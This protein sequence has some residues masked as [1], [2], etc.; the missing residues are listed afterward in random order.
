[1]IKHLRPTQAPASKPDLYSRL[2]LPGA[3]VTQHRR[4]AS[5]D[6]LRAIAALMVLASHAE[7]LGPTQSTTLSRQVSSLGVGVWIFFAASGYLIAGPFLRAL[8]EGRPLPPVR[9]YALR[10]A[11]RILPAYW[12]ALAAILLLANGSA[13]AHWWQLPVHALLLQGLVPG[14][15]KNLYLVAWSLGV[16]AIFYVL[17]PLGAGAVRRR[18]G[19][20]PISV[21]RMIAGVLVLWIAAVAFSL[22][23]AV[24]FP[25]HG[26][27]PLPGAV[28]VLNLVGS[29]A[30]FCPGMLIFLALTVDRKTDSRLGRRY[31]AIA[32]RPLPT[33]VIAGGLF[34]VA[35]SAL[36]FHT[37][38]VAAAAQGP[39]FGVASGLVLI[40]FLHGEWTRPLAKVFAPIG[41]A[42]Y[43]VY[44]WHFAIYTALLKHGV[45]I[46]PGSGNVAV[47][48]RIAFIAAIT[49]PVAMLS[50]LLVERPLLRRTTG[51]ERRGNASAV[52]KRHRREPADPRVLREVSPAS[53]ATSGP[54]ILRRQSSSVSVGEPQDLEPVQIRL[55]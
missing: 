12:V 32:A 27:R 33:L 38:A 4:W 6:A 20:A 30:N 25:M 51:W 5:V 16:E 18:F 15:L 36:P 47:I 55:W 7:F 10:R 40:A 8:L 19:A 52:V 29:L 54:V 53:V 17:V 26:S 11:V 34:I 35:T 28:Q 37:N 2:S 48:V 45:A 23:L 31:T 44:L 39:L 50:W 3:A 13:I 9:R 41:L 14:E 1:M 49:V 46:G 24:A 21:E 42:S 43:G 22:A